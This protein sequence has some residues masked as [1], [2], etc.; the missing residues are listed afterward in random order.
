MVVLGIAAPT[1]IDV[2]APVIARAALETAVAAAAFAA[3]ALWVR[4]NRA[5][6]DRQDWCACAG[7][8][9]TIRVITSRRAETIAPPA[10]PVLVP[11]EENL[12]EAP[13]GR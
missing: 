11:A 4:W 12:K 9:T 10:I 8:K 7:A 13:I 1:A 3:M 2:A 5:A 6:L